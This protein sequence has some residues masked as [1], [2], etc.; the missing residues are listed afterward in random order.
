MRSLHKL[1]QAA[2]KMAFSLALVGA[3]ATTYA[4]TISIPLGQQGKAWQIQTP[5][6]GISK[7]SVQDQY[8]SPMET[9]GPVGEPPITTW[10]YDQFTVY[11]EYDHV[12]H[13]VVKHS[14][15]AQ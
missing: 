8:G 14:A 5:R 13:S 6:T 11:F 2:L 3:A 10:E 7:Q 15:V 4:E 1:A 12:I 9:S